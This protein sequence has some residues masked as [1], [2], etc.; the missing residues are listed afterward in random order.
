MIQQ[1]NF[2]YPQFPY[3]LTFDDVLLLPAFADFS[4]QEINLETKLTRK[5]SLKLPLIAA[6]MDTVTEAALAIA[7]AKEGGIGIL[8]RNLTVEDQA[9]QVRQVKAQNLLVGAAIGVSTGYE[10]R[11]AALVAAG[12]DVIVIDSA[13]GFS[14]AVIN[15]IKYLEATYPELEVIAGSVATYDGAQAMIQAGA[16]AIR[17]RERCG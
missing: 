10:E 2:Q 4:R 12:V 1:D 16:D 9:E 15:V 6:P 3:A 14:Q 5:I 11:V 8:H 13:H 7:I 17:G